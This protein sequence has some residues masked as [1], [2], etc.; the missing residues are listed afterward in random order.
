MNVTEN[1][2]SF[3]QHLLSFQ[4]HLEWEKSENPDI[5][6]PAAADSYINN[7]M[8]MEQGM[9]EWAAYEREVYRKNQRLLKAIKS[10]KGKTFHKHLLEVIEESEGLRSLAT[11]VKEPVGDFQKENYGREIKGIWVQQW[12][13]GDTGD[14]F[15]GNVC[16][17]IKPNKYFKFSYSM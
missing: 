11:I 2:E 9:E 5:T 4:Q 12:S 10:V 3:R 15:E 8:D 13:V 14:S 17:K 7:Q 6:V 16:V 1:K